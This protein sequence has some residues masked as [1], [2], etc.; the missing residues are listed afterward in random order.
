MLPASVGGVGSSGPGRPVGDGVCIS[1]H[2]KWVA[3][4]VVSKYGLRI[5]HTA[6]TV[7][8]RARVATASRF[9]ARRRAWCAMLRWRTVSRAT[10]RRMHRSSA[11]HAT[12]ARCPQTGTGQPRV[13]RTHG[14][15]WK[16]MH[17][18]GDLASCAG[19]HAPD[20]CRAMP[21]G[22]LSA[23][24]RTSAR[25]TVEGGH[26]CGRR[27]SHLPQ[28]R[29]RTVAAVT[30]SRCRIPQASSSGT[31]GSPLQRPIPNARVCHVLDDCAHATTTTSIREALSRLSAATGAASGY[32][33]RGT[34]RLSELCR[35]FAGALPRRLSGASAEGPR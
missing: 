25:P 21:W 11:P 32:L 4:G 15:D 14:P 27:L 33:A 9:T 26:E 29:R 6:C 5:D 17:G 28:E 2:P 30:E 12:S 1:C 16:K 7:G 34:V 3:G 20:S 35:A 23:S 8:V 24:G 19:C 13:R 22:R 10:P 31:A 18:T